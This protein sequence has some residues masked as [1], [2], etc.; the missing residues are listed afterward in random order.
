MR[1]SFCGA[2]KGIVGRL[3]QEP[4]LNRSVV[5]ELALLPYDS[6]PPFLIQFF[7]RQFLP[8]CWAVAAV[9]P[10]QFTGGMDPAQ[11][12]RRRSVWRAGKKSAVERGETVSTL[13]ES[14]G[15][16]PH[17]VVDQVSTHVRR[18]RRTPQSSRPRQ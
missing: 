11:G 12:T 14:S 13:V 9:V 5:K 8:A 17:G 2:S 4:G 7:H 16:R 18:L 3:G 1:G 15:E 6:A 10:R